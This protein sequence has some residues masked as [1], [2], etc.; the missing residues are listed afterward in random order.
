MTTTFRKSAL[1]A[2]LLSLGL[3]AVVLLPAP[4]VAADA[5]LA[6][7]HRAIPAAPTVPAVPAAP[8]IP[9]QSA[10]S[11]PDA[12]S[13]DSAKDNNFDDSENWDSSRNQWRSWG[14]QRRFHQGTNDLVSVGHD[15][16]LAAGATSDSV[17]A[18][19]GSATS[20]GTSRQDVVSVF[21]DTTVNGPASG[22]AVAVL[23]N[24]LVNADIGEDVVAVLG[25][26]TL[27]PNAHVHGHVVSVLGTVNQDPAAVVDHGVERVLAGHFASAEGLR[28]WVVHGLMFG[29][30]LVIGTG[31][32]W[33]WGLSFAFL[34][35][36]TILA[37]LF[38]D[39]TEHCIA[40]LH[41]NPG[42]SLITAILATLLTPLM[43]L[44]LAITVVGLLVIPIAI[45]T[46]FCCAVFGKTTVLGWIGN[47]CFGM[48]PGAAAPHPALA[49]IVGGLIVM[50]AY[51]V[52]VLG[53][54]V[55]ILLGM[56]GYGA[57][58]YALLNR[59]RRSTS[60]TSGA[61]APGGPAAPAGAAPFTE[62]AAAAH[63]AYTAP[64]EA[65]PGPQ[66][67]AAAPG[68]AASQAAPLP[69]TTLPRA[70]FWVRMGALLLDVIIVWAVVRLLLNFPQEGSD[71]L[72]LLALA[73]YGAVMWKVKGTTVGG[74]AC[75]LRVVRLDSR[76]VDW[77]TACVRA[78][79]CILSICALGL[80]FI[81]IAFD[82]GK[83]AWHDKLAGTIVV[84]VPK[85]VPL[86]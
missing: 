27:G 56:L 52:P 65:P 30:P 25:D 58:L 70:T 28:N 7:A 13:A 76:P 26:V 59:I 73:A 54:V 16:H 79:G 14:R 74:I 83:Q 2:T 68:P 10:G 33:L 42:K 53:F 22:S 48:R 24:V 62:P 49:V 63:A 5:T 60:G 57:V 3:T 15:A 19:F 40:T 9:E 77:P 44:L 72:V 4:S 1:V 21:G 11:A 61:T 32:Q 20:D 46:L 6:A 39:A 23:G 8:A 84:R 71:R 34:A 37:L 31:L 81:W 41:A 51:L 43:F 75:D 50:L 55:F 29:R 69:L 35:V 67:D 18:V 47:R 64:P 17:V 38:R 66:A 86:V 45:V 85:G 78:L 36:Y 82:P 80:G 12:D